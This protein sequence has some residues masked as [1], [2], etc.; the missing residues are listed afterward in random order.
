MY[1]ATNRQKDLD[2]QK[3]RPKKTEAMANGLQK[4]VWL[5]REEE[6]RFRFF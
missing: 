3:D 2:R 4:A 6:Y 1:K 5:S